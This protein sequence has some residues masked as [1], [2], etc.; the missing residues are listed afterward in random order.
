MVAAHAVLARSLKSKTSIGA[1][2]LDTNVTFIHDLSLAVRIRGLLENH[3][4]GCP[5]TAWHRAGTE[6]EP[7]H[8]VEAIHSHLAVLDGIDFFTVEVLT[9]HGLVTYY[10]LFFI[11]LESR[12]VSLAG[13][14]R[15]LDQAWMQQMARNATG[16]AWGSWISDG[17]HCMNATRNSARGSERC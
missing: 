1:A 13:I 3:P 16:E 5:E 9:W 10:V 2:D 6:T 11:H 15:H 17:T 12:R 7:K 14:T 4:A 8:D